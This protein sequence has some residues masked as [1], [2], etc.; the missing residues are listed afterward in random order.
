MANYQFQSTQ[1]PLKWRLL[2]K[3]RQEPPNAEET[4]VDEPLTEEAVFSMMGY[5]A[6]KELPPFSLLG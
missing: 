6:M 2:S 5:I 4:D 3:D 1:R